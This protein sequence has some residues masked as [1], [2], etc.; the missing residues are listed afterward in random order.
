MGKRFYDAE[1]APGIL[2]M[3]KERDILMRAN[4]A[5]GFILVY[6][7]ATEVDLLIRRFDEERKANPVLE[8]TPPE[9]W[10][11]AELVPTIREIRPNI[12]TEDELLS[13]AIQ[14]ILR[15]FAPLD[16]IAKHGEQVL[17]LNIEP[18]RPCLETLFLNLFDRTKS[19]RSI[20]GLRRATYSLR[21]FGRDTKPFTKL[22]EIMLRCLKEKQKPMR[23][24]IALDEAGVRPRSPEKYRSYVHMLG[25]N[26]HS[27][28]SL[29][30][31]IKTKYRT[32]L[33][34]SVIP[35]VPHLN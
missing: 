28:Y 17:W 6:N 26:S 16:D 7:L 9:A 10:I 18:Y 3:L 35:A 30:N 25:I 14:R 21:D 33:M 34:N 22:D 8:T 4:R 2:V 32:H 20:L 1:F 29:K 31:N 23:I 24:A 15:R 12:D 27:F 5:Q 11:T 19:L 13:E